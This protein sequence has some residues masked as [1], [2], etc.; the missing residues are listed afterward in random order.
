ML[1][2]LLRDSQLD[3]VKPEERIG[4]FNVFTYCDS[5][6]DG[7]EDSPSPEPWDET[8]LPRESFELD[9]LLVCIEGDDI[10][11]KNHSD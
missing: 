4:R 6:D 1:G 5:D 3:A 11:T 7:I 8:P 9:L 2:G 10:I